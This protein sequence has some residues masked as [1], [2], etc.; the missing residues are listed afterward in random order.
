[1]GWR[2]SDKAETLRGKEGARIG[3]W[4]AHIGHDGGAKLF[5]DGKP[6][7]CN[8]T[9]QNPERPDR[10]QVSVTLAKGTHEILVAF[11]LDETRGWG[12]HL[13]FSVP[14]K[15]RAGGGV[16]LPEGMTIA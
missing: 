11:D 7:Y 6:V 2:S 5:I 13:N 9:L 12:I 4:N 14:E 1:M 3:T 15:Q 16:V 10:A 8:P